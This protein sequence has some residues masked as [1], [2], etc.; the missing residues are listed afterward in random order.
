MMRPC[1]LAASLVL[2]SG[3]QPVLQQ[4]S[5]SEP[6]KV[7]SLSAAVLT[8]PV[9]QVEIASRGANAPLSR[10]AVNGDVETW[11]AVDN[12]SVSLR[13]GVLVASRGL[14]FDLMGADAQG[15]LDALAGYDGG[16]YRR[17]MRYLTGEQHSTYLMAGCSMVA[18]GSETVEG[19]RLRRFEESCK[20][21]QNEF[22][23]IFWLDGNGTVIR[24]RQWLSP[25][26][27]YLAISL[28]R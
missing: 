28:I 24:S 16:V 21:R 2:L 27:G 1:L 10:V 8:G 15:T 14:G 25:E 23:N 17:Q 22:T 20:A 12:I 7:T 5:G 26:I 4:L 19:Q 13:Q 18:I 11:L 6:S 9:M 3:C